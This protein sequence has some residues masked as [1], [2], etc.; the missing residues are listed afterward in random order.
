MALTN[1]K[2]NYLSIGAVARLKKISV[3]AL[4]YYE[5]IGIFTPAYINPE[6][7]YR[8]YSIEQ[9]YILDIILACVELGIPLKKFQSYITEDHSIDLK[10]MVND[11][12]KY[13]NQATDRLLQIENKLH[14]ISDHLMESSHLEQHKQQDNKQFPLRYLFVKPVESESLARKQYLLYMSELY[15]QMEELG[16]SNKYH[17][18]ILY[19]KISDSTQCYIYYEI[20]R[21]RTL[22]KEEKGDILLLPAG[23]YFQQLIS[24]ED[25][26]PFTTLFPFS[27][28]YQYI[29]VQERYEMHFNKSPYWELQYYPCHD[30]QSDECS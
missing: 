9:M 28:K 2:D 1:T 29:L 5:Q 11:G 10:H 22:S 8:Y 15:M 7:G 18:G 16:Y 27:P 4:R 26:S 13:V 24:R 3:K 14:N 20:E 19:Q 23:I 12:I 17:Q 25:W 6:T 21:P 30:S